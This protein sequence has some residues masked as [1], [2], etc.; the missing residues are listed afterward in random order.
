VYVIKN[1]PYRATF[2]HAAA[3]GERHR[4]ELQARTPPTVLQTGASFIL[5]PVLRERER[6]REA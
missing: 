3:A 4:I 5:V 2:H 6:E 1:R